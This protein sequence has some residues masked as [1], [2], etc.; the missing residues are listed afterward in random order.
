M[1]SI[2]RYESQN[3]LLNTRMI[4]LNKEKDQVDKIM[5]KIQGETEEDVAIF[6]DKLHTSSELVK[7]NVTS[8]CRLVF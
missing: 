4:D 5:K 3:G 7:A 1:D 6:I 8:K 2:D